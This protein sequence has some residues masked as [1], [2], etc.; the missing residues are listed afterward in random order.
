MTEACS[1]SEGPVGREL[2]SLAWPILCSAVLTVLDASVNA[3]WVGR[4]L[5]DVALAALSNAN[6]LWIMLFSAAFGLTTAGAVRVGKSLGNGDLDGAKSALAVTVGVSWMVSVGCAVA[7][8]LWARA[9]LDCLGTPAQSMKQ[10]VDYIQI[11]LLSLP[12]GYLYGAVIAGLRAAGDSKIAFQFSC[13][14]VAADIVLNPALIGGVGPLGPLGIRGSAFAT[15]V[16]QAIGLAG[17]ASHLRRRH[18]PLSFRLRDLR[19]LWI[20]IHTAG[21]LFR[22]GAPMAMQFLWGTVEGML[23]ISLVNRFGPDTTAAYGAVM[24]VWNLIAMPAAALSVATTSIVAQNI[25]AGRWYRVRTATRVALIYVICVTSA[26]VA[27]AEMLDSTTFRLFLPAGSPALVI[28][29][30]IN[31]EATWWL[32]AYGAYAVWVGVLRAVG[33]VW[34]PLAISVCVLAVRFPLTDALLRA[35]RAEAIWWSFPVSATAIGALAVLH[36]WLSRRARRSFLRN[37]QPTRLGT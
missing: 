8:E 1:I 28:A 22:Q 11:L 24:Q 13:V 26:L 29:T 36:V 2:L 23:I 31:L 5:G 6:L 37:L 17:L 35:W 20:D 9:L 15:V 16:S 33:V 3:V 12:L 4:K 19:L 25:G 27:L 18:H 30:Q 7:M 34:V 32:I 10:A 14:A 21:M